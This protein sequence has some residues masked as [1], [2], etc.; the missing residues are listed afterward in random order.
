MRRFSTVILMIFWLLAGSGFAQ[1]A[2]AAPAGAGTA[3]GA[4]GFFA[5]SPASFTLPG[6]VSSLAPLSDGRVLAGGQFI[7]IGGQPAP[8]SLAMIKSDGSLDTA[9]QVDAAL[10]VREIYAAALQPN[11]KIVIAGLFR[12]Q[13]IPLTYYLV[14]LEASGALD[15]TFNPPT[16]NGPV[17]AVMMDGEKIVIGGNFST[18]GPRIARL[19]ADGT[20][21]PAFNGVGS[22]PDGMLRAIARQSSG[23]YIIAGEFSSYNGTSQV[24][25]ARLSTTGALDPSFAPGG[26]RVSQRV[27]VLKDNSV[28]VGGEDICGASVFHW[29]TASG[30]AKTT[31]AQ[32]PNNFDAITALLPLADG[33]FLIGGWR[34]PSCIGSSPTEHTG[35][36][37]R[38]AASGAYQALT[39]FGNESDVLAL[40]YRSD[41]KVLLGG[42]GRPK[43][44]SQIGLLDGLALLD[45]ANNSLGQVAAFH[46]LVGDEAEINSLS[47]Y[48]DG[49][50]L[51]GGNFSHVDGS[52]RFGVAR[53][54]ANRALDTS[55]HPFADLPGGW[56]RAVLALSD[57]R[58]LAGFRSSELYLIG[59]DGSRTDLS[60]FNNFERVSAL[61]MQSDNKVLVGS[62]FGLG[63]RRLKADFSGADT[64]FNNGAAYGNVYALAVQGTKIIVA[65]DFSKFNNVTVPGLVRLDSSGVIDSGFTPPV[66][67]D[68]VGN[69]AVVYSLT[70]LASGSVLV[71]G[72]FWTVGGA[73]HP[74]LVRLTGTGALDTGF[75]SPADF[76]T[77]KSA[78]VLGDGSI[79]AGG[80]ENTYFQNPLLGH[81]DQNGAPGADFAS[82]F[83]GAHS[84]GVVNAVECDPS[85]LTWTGG[86]FSLI[87]GRAFYDLAR[88]FSL[89]GQAFLAIVRR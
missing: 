25:L 74:A 32:D 23:Q 50:L 68:E 63:L 11:G 70:P 14:R 82:A 42:Q 76:Q 77:V 10:K 3:H 47:R 37:W 38:Y 6:K 24:G 60:V 66:F 7:S 15:T 49:R 34:S 59:L 19:G 45:L 84:D 53:L 18:L 62:N 33:G 1:P 44:A 81:F 12:Q 64:T 65:G 75:S 41:G 58:A 13:S 71:G 17:M 29:Y 72:Y 35:Q 67:Q 8:S 52:P 61:A 9:F 20:P 21:D 57:G 86:R 48:P 80:I 79:W 51:V 89:G 31:P 87:D 5:D 4:S 85:G 2:A 55:F 54:L 56:S 40:A 22:G 39:S 43:D 83:Q 30:A 73:E 36:V 88:Y 26:F 46:P 16:V 28:V 27:A 69:S 78:C